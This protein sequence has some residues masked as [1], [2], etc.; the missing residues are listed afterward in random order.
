MVLHVSPRNIYKPFYVLLAVIEN[1]K[2][3]AFLPFLPFLIPSSFSFLLAVHFYLFI[4]VTVELLR[5]GHLGSQRQ[6]TVF[7][8]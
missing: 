3:D 8:R 2:N 4:S 5:N 6:V 1:S 7:E